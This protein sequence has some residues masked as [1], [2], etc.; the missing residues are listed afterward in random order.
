MFMFFCLIL[1][2]SLF[3]FVTFSAQISEYTIEAIRFGTLLQVCVIVLL[4]VGAKFEET[5][6]IAVVIWLIRGNGRNILFDIGYHRPIS[7]FSERWN[8]KDYVRLDEVVKLAKIQ[9]NT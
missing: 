3:Q 2:A 8:I 4:L 9:P 1:L 7:G 6:D 5:F